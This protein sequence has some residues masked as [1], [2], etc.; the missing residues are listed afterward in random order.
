MPVLV[1]ESLQAHVKIVVKMYQICITDISTELHL[2]TGLVL[3]LVMCFLA[4]L[5]EP[6]CLH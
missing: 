4:E 2:G 3:L 6:N 1:A 5:H